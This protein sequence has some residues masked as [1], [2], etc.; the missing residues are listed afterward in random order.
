MECSNKMS[1]RLAWPNRLIFSIIFIDMQQKIQKTK[2]FVYNHIFLELSLK[3]LWIRI[4][5]YFGNFNYSPFIY[6]LYEATLFSFK[7]SH[8][9]LKPFF[10]DVLYSNRSLFM[11]LKTLKIRNL[12]GLFLPC[13]KKYKTNNTS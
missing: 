3:V 10:I 4:F 1:D 9:L 11:L 6:N 2:S 7:A 12:F 8:A 5:L 13:H